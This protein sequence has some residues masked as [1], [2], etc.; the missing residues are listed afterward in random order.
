MKLL[1]L[2]LAL[3]CLGLLTLSANAQYIFNPGWYVLSLEN[4]LS[5]PGFESGLSPW[6]NSSSYFYTG[7]DDFEGGFGS[8]ASGGHSGASSYDF[9]V[10][11]GSY[12]QFWFSALEQDLTTPVAGSSI[13]V[14]SVWVSAG[15]QTLY[16]NVLYTDGTSSYGSFQ[17]EPYSPQQKNAWQQ[18]NFLS[19]INPNKMVKGLYFSADSGGWGDIRIDDVSLDIWVWIYY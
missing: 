7:G 14:G 10:G 6:N 18:W 5:D 4:L 12:N 17:A 19:L 8:I 9:Y 2:A 11:E 16:L 3:G 15:Y 13:A 1:R